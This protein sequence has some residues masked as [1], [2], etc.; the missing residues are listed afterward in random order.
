M[1]VAVE[2]DFSKESSAEAAASTSE[3]N[4]RWNVSKG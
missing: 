1:S 2:Y 3:W 4:E